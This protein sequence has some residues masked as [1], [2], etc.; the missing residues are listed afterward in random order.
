MG[1]LTN[2]NKW[3]VLEWVAITPFFVYAMGVILVHKIT[4]KITGNHE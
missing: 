3:G 1:W 4:E 2:S